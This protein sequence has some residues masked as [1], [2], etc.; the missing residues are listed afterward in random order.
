MAGI[1]SA[2]L[3]RSDGIADVR[4]V[5]GVLRRQPATEIARYRTT[6]HVTPALGFAERIVRGHD[7]QCIRRQSTS[8]VGAATDVKGNRRS[9]G[10]IGE[11]Y[12]DFRPNTGHRRVGELGHPSKPIRTLVT[13]GRRGDY[14]FA[15]WIVVADRRV[16]PPGSANGPGIVIGGLDNLDLIGDRLGVHRRVDG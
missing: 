14:R 12:G 13:R 10:T 16:Q 15:V 7:P 8:V 3:E 9:D 11:V 1:P 4:K 6:G 2:V 5:G